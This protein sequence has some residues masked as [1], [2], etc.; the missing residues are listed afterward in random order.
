[1]FGT[2]GTLALVLILQTAGGQAPASN[3]QPRDGRGSAPRRLTVTYSDGTSRTRLLT[4]RGGSWTPY[5]PHRPDAPAQDGLPLSALDVSHVVD[6]DLVTVTVALRYGLPQLRT[7]PVVTIQMKG[8]EPVTVSDLSRF[9]VDPIVLSIDDFPPPVL[10]NPTSASISPLIDVNAELSRNDLPVYKVT[11]RNRGTRAVMALS[12]EMSRSG[13]TVATSHWKT[14]RS[15]PLIAAGNEYV[16]AVDVGSGPTPGF[17]RFAVTGVIWDDGSAEG[18]E[19]LKRGEEG[20]ALGYALQLRRVLTVLRESPSTDGSPDS[21][22]FAQIRNAI[23]ALPVATN[24][25]ERLAA[26]Q[27]LLSS[28][29]VVIGQQQVKQAVLDDLD[30]YLRTTKNAGAGPQQ[31]VAGARATYSAWLRRTGQP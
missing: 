30:G 13:V 5:F 6:G 9:G 28:T 27:K 3:Q 17:D 14:N 21:R 19:A 11:V 10:V 8:D 31:W 7:V 15:E 29:A 16:K 23:A 2:I 1:M 24:Q 22:T 20:L 25:E 18:N 12:I 4:P 26:N